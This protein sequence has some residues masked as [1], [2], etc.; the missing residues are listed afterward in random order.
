MFDSPIAYCSLKGI[1]V[2]LD[3]HAAACRAAHSCSGSHCPL[4]SA[5]EVELDIRNIKNAG[6]AAS[7]RSAL[8]LIQGVSEVRLS[9]DLRT[10]RVCF[11]PTKVEPSQFNRALRAVGYKVSGASAD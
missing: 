7:A 2:A 4:F 9:E 1:W 6:D 10:V 3:E 11:D 8:A 5:G